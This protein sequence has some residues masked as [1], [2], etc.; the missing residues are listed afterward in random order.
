MIQTLLGPRGLPQRHGP[1]FRAPRRRGGDGRGFRAVLRRRLRR[2]PHAVHALVLAGR[3]AR[4]RRDRHATMRARRPI[5]S[6]SRRRVPPTP[7]QPSKEPMVIPL[8]I[9]LVG[10]R[11]ARPAAQARRRAERSSAAC[12]RSTKRRRASPS[13]ISP[14]APV[15]SLNRGFSA[16][17]KLVANRAADDLRFLAAHDTDPFNRWQAVQTLATRCSRRRRG[18]A[19]GGAARQD[20]GLIERSAR[21]WPTARSSRRSSRWR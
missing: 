19:R 12:C 21:S 16:P 18:D 3:H 11:R 13:A 6:T 15:P 17:I 1:L 10:A 9:G 8:A 7:G 4:G 20:D 14:S 2:R 5:G